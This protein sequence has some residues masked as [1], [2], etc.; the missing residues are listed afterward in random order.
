M[1]WRGIWESVSGG[2]AR[3][4]A[5]WH[6]QTVA[7]ARRARWYR[8]PF[9]V[10]DD[11]DGRFDMIALVAWVV[12]ER[13]G[14]RPDAARARR[15]FLECL[16]DDFEASLREAGVG[17]QGIPKRVRAMAEA[18]AGRFDAYG[19]AR[20]RADAPEALAL[21]IER[22]VFRADAPTV[23]PGARALALQAL[24]WRATLMDKPDA[25]LRPGRSLFDEGAFR[26][27]AGIQPSRDARRHS[28]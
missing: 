18:L 6:R 25:A 28:P 17:D 11:W 3:A 14:A 26:H 2:R 15:A 21:A 22:N 1:D 23:R 10:A 7:W 4:A 13:L 8:P 24:A 27:D 20:A 5:H 19:A 9:G 16:V 12:Q